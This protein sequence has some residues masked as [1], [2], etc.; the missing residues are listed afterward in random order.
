MTT[1]FSRLPH[2]LLVDILERVCSLEDVHSFGCVCREFRQFLLDSETRGLWNA[3]C[4]YKETEGATSLFV[5]LS[6][7][8]LQRILDLGSCRPKPAT[9]YYRFQPQN[10]IL[11]IADGDAVCITSAALH[12]EFVIPPAFL[13]MLALGSLPSSY[14]PYFTLAKRWKK[15]RT[16]STLIFLVY[17]PDT[18]QC[19]FQT[20]WVE[21]FPE[22]PGIGS[23]VRLVKALAHKFVPLESIEALQVAVENLHEVLS[24]VYHLNK[25]RSDLLGMISIVHDQKQAVT[26]SSE[27]CGIRE[28]CVK[29]FKEAI[30]GIGAWSIVH[31]QFI[32]SVE[33]DSQSNLQSRGS[34]STRQ[35]VNHLYSACE[36][37]KEVQQYLE[38]GKAQ[39]TLLKLVIHCR[40]RKEVMQY[41]RII[42]SM[43]D[44]AF[45][46]NPEL[47][48]WDSTSP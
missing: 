20:E 48:P 45:L 31:R 7:N 13:S 29:D 19:L 8:K 22:Y 39:K 18:T 36:Q 44:H 12:T 40:D 2:Q 1:I 26:S 23:S 47:E 28:F 3:F 21:T 11:G 4:P 37:V 5:A 14:C 34:T 6:Y 24:Q 32:V 15:T 41:K 30:K 10:R 42:Q 46:L 33:L 35:R 17:S 16:E 38:T 9:F 25:Q 43:L 27:Y